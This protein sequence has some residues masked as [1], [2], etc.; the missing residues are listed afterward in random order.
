M[1]SLVEQATERDVTLAAVLGSMAGSVVV[2][3]AAHEQSVT[4]GRYPELVIEHEAPDLLADPGAGAALGPVDVMLVSDG[5]ADIG[6]GAITD[7]VQHEFGPVD[8]DR[9]LV[10]LAAPNESLPGCPAC[11]G[12]RFGFPADLA[13]ARGEMCPAHQ[14][15]AGSVINARIARANASNPDGWGALGDASA[16]LQRPHLPNGLA[17]KLA[18]AGESMYIVPERGVLSTD[19][20]QSSHPVEQ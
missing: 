9:S 18:G 20:D 12:H 8:L 6:L 7:I 15:E 13:E 17:T 5:W 19:G 10:E 4:V 1:W 16:R 14:R 3:A 11:A 2:T